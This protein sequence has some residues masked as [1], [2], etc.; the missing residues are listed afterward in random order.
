MVAFQTWPQDGFIRPSLVELPREKERELTGLWLYQSL[1]IISSKL[2]LLLPA[3]G[4]GQRRQLWI[5]V[6][7]LH[8]ALMHL[9]SNRR[10]QKGPSLWEQVTG[11]VS[12]QLL[13]NDRNC[14]GLISLFLNLYYPVGKTYHNEMFVISLLFFS[15]TAIRLNSELKWKCLRKISF[16]KD[17]APGEKINA[18]IS[19]CFR[20]SRDGKV[21]S[22]PKRVCRKS[23]VKSIK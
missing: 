6:G 15:Q 9:W 21:S 22:S 1:P 13:T 18:V 7:S 11:F 23:A 4:P 17:L 2:S 10:V 3:G 12:R 14:P 8:R 16:F 20:I 5:K 19:V